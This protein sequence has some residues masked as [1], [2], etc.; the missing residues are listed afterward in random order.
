MYV[1]ISSIWN[2]SKL[3]L[4]DL[5]DI[6]TQIMSVIT[7]RMCT[8]YAWYHKRNVKHQGVRLAKAQ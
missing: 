3:S 1:H 8:M 4:F 5:F 7:I 6:L 2:W